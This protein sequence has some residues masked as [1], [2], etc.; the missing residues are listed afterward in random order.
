MGRLVGYARVST[1]EQDVDLQLDA[2]REAGCRDALIFVDKVSGAKS[3]RPG[4]DACI[5]ALESGDTLL[6]WRLDR[7]GRSMPHLVTL[8]QEL[9]KKGVA[10]RSLRD[11][12]IDTTSASGELV[13]HIFSALAQFERRLIQERTKAG[14]SAARARGRQGGRRAITR[15]DPRVKT[16]CRM[17]RDHELSVEQICKTLDI[18]RATF[19]RYPRGG[20]RADAGTLINELGEST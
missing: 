10:F 14:L 6:V 12:A 2:L 15:N 18:S 11:G 3:Q 19:Y 7:L 17:H 4:L 16:A 1:L 9:L 20:Q 5:N 13:F 8:I